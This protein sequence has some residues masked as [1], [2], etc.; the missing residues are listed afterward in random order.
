MSVLTLSDTEIERASDLVLG[1]LQAYERSLT[2]RPVMPRLD[3]ETLATLLHDPFPETGAGFEPVFRE[4]V[5]R[6]A[7]NSTAVAH[8]RFLAYVLGPPNGVAPFAEAL[9]A[10]LNQNCNF[11]Q[12][13][14][15]A[16]V[17]EQRVLSWFAELFEYPD[18]AGGIL[19]SGGSMATVSA[20]AAA[21]HRHFP[22]DYRRTGLQGLRAPLVA[23]ASEEAHGCVEKGAVLLG[24]GQQGIRRIPTDS[25][26]HMR[27]DLLAEA[28]HTD[29][30]QGKQPFCVVATCGAV[31]T[32][33]IDPIEEIAEF[34]SSENLWLHVDGAFGAFFV[35]SPR[36]R[37]RLRECRRADSIALDPH[38][39]LFAPLEAVE[40][41]APYL[42]NAHDPLLMNFM[43]YGPQL[44]RGFKALKIWCSL[45]TFGVSAFREAIERT[46]DLAQYM[47]AR[48]RR[49]GVFELLAPVELNAV[50]FKLKAHGDDENRALLENLIEDGTALLGPVRIG[51]KLGLR[52]CVT[53]HRTR[54]ADI[55]AVLDRLVELGTAADCVHGKRDT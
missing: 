2:D 4:I 29:R 1:F 10:A 20:L 28:V 40:F 9:A 34:C 37:D 11:W 50:C 25:S 24:L 19:T 33:A 55:D 35:L 16:N 21:L 12:L 3:R 18:T 6:I 51:G 22:G 7:P 27:V 43:D 30:K 15:A 41:D 49:D 53:N 54:R 47:E 42:S 38:K 45:R 8:P 36:I 52:A 31:N 17:I 44:S 5:E 23:Y 46:L 32:G 13:S 48:I 39:L 26:F 14:P